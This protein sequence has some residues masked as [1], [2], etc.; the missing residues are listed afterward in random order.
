MLNLEKILGENY[1]K[2][3]DIVQVVETQMDLLQKFLHRKD[4]DRLQN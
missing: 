4:P 3:T 2:D 1:Q